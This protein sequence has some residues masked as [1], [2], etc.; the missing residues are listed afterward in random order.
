MSFISKAFESFS[1]AQ[2]YQIQLVQLGLE[3][4]PLCDSIRYLIIQ[5]KIP[6]QWL[7]KRNKLQNFPVSNRTI[8]RFLLKETA[9]PQPTTL[10]WIVRYIHAFI[11][12]PGQTPPHSPPSSHSSDYEDPRIDMRQGR[13]LLE[14]G[15]TPMLFHPEELDND[16]FKEMT[17][18]EVLKIL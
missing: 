3:N 4:P 7:F 15:I 16:H 18:P 11:Y 14:L 10:H 12:P 1:Q 17:R 8:Q 9:S 2:E 13:E 5:H 6:D